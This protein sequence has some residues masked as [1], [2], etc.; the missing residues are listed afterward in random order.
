[1]LVSDPMRTS[2]SRKLYIICKY[3]NMFY[4]RTLNGQVFEP[5]HSLIDPKPYYENCVFDSCGC[6]LGGDCMCFCEALE[7]YARQCSNKRVVLNWRVQTKECRKF[8]FTTED[9]ILKFSK[10]Y[11]HDSKL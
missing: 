11:H 2:N 8:S 3:P 5:C 4:L 10:Y 7:T 1:M 9:L 6:D